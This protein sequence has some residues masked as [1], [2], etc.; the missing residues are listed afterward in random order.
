[1]RQVFITKAG[2]PQVLQV[3]ESPDPSAG[4]GEVRVRVKAAGIYAVVA[5]EKCF[6]EDQQLEEHFNMNLEANAKVETHEMA[7]AD[8]TIAS[9]QTPYPGGL[10]HEMSDMFAISG[11]FDYTHFDSLN[12]FA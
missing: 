8:F 5:F 9:I 11:V 2:G 12:K 6:R 10:A 4:A 7:E 3:R 1:M